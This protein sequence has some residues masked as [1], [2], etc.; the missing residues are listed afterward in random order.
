M[1]GARIALGKG[2]EDSFCGKR[3]GVDNVSAREGVENGIGQQGRGGKLGRESLW[4]VAG[5]RIA[6]GKGGEDSFSGKRDRV[7]NVSARESV[8]NGT[9]GQDRGW[10]RARGGVEDS[11]GGWKQQ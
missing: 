7:D 8:E 5:A 4:H 3:D 9:C 2:G 6:F 11:H 1:A 10:L